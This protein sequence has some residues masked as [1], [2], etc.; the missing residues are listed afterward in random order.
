MPPRR[1]LGGV[2]LVGSDA[3][4][5]AEIEQFEEVEVRQEYAEQRPRR[6]WVFRQG[7]F[8]TVA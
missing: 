5:Q 1:R 6:A 3:G 4:E 2:A 7:Q 8:E